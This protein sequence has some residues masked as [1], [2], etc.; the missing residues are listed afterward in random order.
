MICFGRT[1]SVPAWIE[2]HIS[3]NP[4][5]RVRPCGLPMHALQTPRLSNQLYYH[6][7][8]VPFQPL[9][10]VFFGQHWSWA[11]FDLPAQGL[12]SPQV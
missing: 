8:P 3:S 10:C 2:P 5:P 4:Q 9:S 11:A 6:I 1:R 7:S 12:Q